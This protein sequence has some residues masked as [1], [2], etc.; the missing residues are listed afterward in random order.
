MSPTG[1]ALR[2]GRA[3]G[4]IAI[5]MMLAGLW[6][7]RELPKAVYPEMDFPR[8]QVV[9]SLPGAAAKAVQVGVTRPL[10]EALASIPGLVHLRSRTLRG[11]AELSLLFAS[12][13]DMAQAHTLVLARL[14]ETRERLAQG[15]E[16]TAE[17]VS[18]SGFPI[19]SLNMTGPYPPSQLYG[20]AQYTLAP[21]LAGLPGVGRI[22]VQASEV[23]EVQVLLDPTRLA[24]AHLTTTQVA[25]ALSASNSVKAVARVERAHELVLGV[26]SGEWRSLSELSEVVVGGSTEAPLRLRD[27]GEVREGVVPRTTII[28]VDGGPGVILNIARRANG[29]ILALDAAVKARLAEIAPSL[30][31]GI[32]LRPVYEQAEFVREAAGGVRDSVLFGALFAVGVLALFLRDARATGV[33]AVA[34]PLTLGTTLLL[35]RALGQSLNLMTLGGLAIS[36]G[37]VIDDAVVVTEAVHAELERGLSPEEATRRGTD[38]LFGPVVGTTATTLVVF[39]PL[40]L[41]SGVAGHF[42][43]ALALSLCAAV[44]VSLPVAL[45]VLPPLAARLLRPLRSPPPRA[46]LAGKYLQAL[47]WVLGHRGVVLGSALGAVVLA[48]LLALRLPTGFLP[49]ADEGSYVVDFF[50]P[51]SSA[52]GAAESL[53]AG[54]EQAL[55][56]S[57]EVVATSRRLG[58]ELGPPT[59]TLPSRGDVAVR[60]KTGRRRNIE[61]IMDEQR[62]RVAARFP[63]V[64]VEFIQVLADM[65][66]D[67]QGA[68]EPLELRIFGPE[69]E[70]LAGL[71]SEAARRIAPV[72]GLTD[73]FGGDE[74][75]TPELDLQVDSLAAARVGLNATTLG[76]QL[77]DGYLGTIATQLRRPDHL[78]DVRVRLALPSPLP[79]QALDHARV[80]TALGTS[81]PL[82]I[83][84]AHRE[85]CESAQLLRDNQ[86]NEVHLTSRL[87]GTS[88]GTAARDVRKRLQGWALPPGYTFELGGML[89]AQTR[90][91]N[92][93]LLVLAVSLSCVLAVLLFQLRSYRLSLAVLSAAPLGL[94]GG[95]LALWVSGESLNVSSMMGGVLLVGL[96]VKNGILLLDHARLGEEGGMSRSEALLEA[97]RARLRPI[98]MT[99]V[100]TLVALIPLLL[101]LSAG[102]ELH[103]PLAW[104]V[105]GGLAFSTLGTLFVLPAVALGRLR[106]GPARERR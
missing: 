7:A 100:A 97:G 85:H 4:F 27:V 54:L 53:S 21:A 31:P 86:R 79:T 61:D 98:V 44:L 35:L 2:H 80:L 76:A 15:T 45:L 18:A 8:E 103:R 56:E 106:G 101:G 75:C 37:L 28:Q 49:E 25:A 19:L 59:A 23:P 32:T 51:V 9:A 91:F 36:V 10:E 42:F 92:D 33:A 6:V 39:L 57:P 84:G 13:T 83:L 77:A 16:L 55:R 104:V 66:G 43:S 20:L 88:L 78:E 93:L 17:R 52:L 12:D 90:S 34:L 5:A 87:S 96:V 29:D 65:L 105:V 38:A 74:G 60:L 41:L 89:E 70:V 94:V 73:V 11:A 50:V 58:A 69:P 62:A 82:G 40:G 46:R 71:A 24:A 3:T 14:G 26:V 99:T 47:Q 81:I 1:W 95:V 22:T 64:R 67:L 48:S 102:G 30:P 63:G 72:P 68:S